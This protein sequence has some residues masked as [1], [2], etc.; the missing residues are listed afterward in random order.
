MAARRSSIGRS[1][2]AGGLVF[3]CIAIFGEKLWGVHL[4]Y[5]SMRS[6]QRV[7]GRFT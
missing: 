1:M 5:A 4:H 2:A 6:W 3:I 7:E